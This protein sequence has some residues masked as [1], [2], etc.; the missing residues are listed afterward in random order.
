MLLVMAA[1]VS[2]R[3]ADLEMVKRLDQ[4]Y[5]QSPHL[6]LPVIIVVLTHIDLLRRCVSGLRHTIGGIR[7]LPRSNR[8]R[9][10]LTMCENFLAIE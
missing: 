7:I 4:H 6:K 8:S 2:A 1:N 5:R 10:P 3:K 9:E